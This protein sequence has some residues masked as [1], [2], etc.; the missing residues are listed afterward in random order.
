MIPDRGGSG[1]ML[2][3]GGQHG[4]VPGQ[5]GTLVYLNVDSAFAIP[6]TRFKLP[7]SFAE[8]T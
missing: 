3:Q 2:V 4:Y 8:R 7:A 5:Q 6:A 1:G